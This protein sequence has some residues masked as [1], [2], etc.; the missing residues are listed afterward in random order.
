MK[1]S[2]DI[3]ELLEM[4]ELEPICDEDNSAIKDSQFIDDQ[5]ELLS[6]NHESNYVSKDKNSKKVSTIIIASTLVIITIFGTLFVTEDYYENKYGKDIYQNISEK[7][8]EKIKSNDT[9]ANSS[10][11]P[12]TAEPSKTTVREFINKPDVFISYEDKEN[13]YNI[14]MLY[15]EGELIAI[16]PKIKNVFIMSEPKA[17]SLQMV[18]MYIKDTDLAGVIGVYHNYL[19]VYF[20]VDGYEYY[21]WVRM[22]DV[23]F[24]SVDENSNIKYMTSDEFDDFISENVVE[25]NNNNDSVSKVDES[26]KPVNNSS[27]VSSKGTNTKVENITNTTTYFTIGST[28]DQVK[29]V[30]G[31][32]SSIND[33]TFFET[34]NYGINTIEFTDGKVSGYHDYDKVLKVWLGDKISNNFFTINSSKADVLKANGT[35]SGIADY[36]SFET[37]SYG[38]NTIEFTENRVSGYHDYDNILNVTLGNPI[39]GKTFGVGST[40]DDVIKANGTPSGI[41][42]YGYSSTWY[43][44]F[45]TVSFDS[46]GYVES[47]NNWDG[48]LKI[49]F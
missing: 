23:E 3:N 48:N 38:I 41:S 45:S 34:W 42:D 30:M 18:N 31:K 20:P 28:K 46:N 39:S 11:V 6:R 29:L 4:F 47:Y 36:T 22:G 24:Y 2:N 13:Y 10:S 17:S 35:P 19:H 27:S 25:S 49:G 37:W 43:Y 32:P 1:N 33:Y 16:T 12:T 14:S 26:S 7:N 8:D 21:G 9:S 44:G 5:E 40:K 15:E